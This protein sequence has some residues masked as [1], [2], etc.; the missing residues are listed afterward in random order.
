[1]FVTW[2]I[3][4]YSRLSSSDYEWESTPTVL[5][6]YYDVLLSASIG[7]GKDTFSFKMLNNNGALDSYFNIGDKVSIYRAVNTTTIDSSNLLMSGIITDLPY[8]VDGSKNILTVKGA[9]YTEM[10]MN[11]I[12][13]VSAENLTI[14]EYLQQALNS[15]NAFNDNFKITWSSSNPSLNSNDQPFP[16]IDEKWNYK[17][18]LL[19]LEKYS[20]S[21]YTL[22]GNYYFFI[23]NINE[24]V[25]AKRSDSSTDSF[26]SSTD[27]HKMLSIKKDLKG[28]VNFVIIKGKNSPGGKIISTRVDDPISRSKNGFK[29]KIIISQANKVSDLLQIDGINQNSYNGYP[30]DFSSPFTTVWTCHVNRPSNPT[31]DSGSTVTCNSDNEYDTAIVEEMKGYWL[32]QEGIAYINEYKNGKKMIDIEFI[33]GKSWGLGDVINCTIPQADKNNNPMRVSEVQYSTTGDVYTLIEDE[34]TL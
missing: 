26:D 18:L 5:N 21:K 30:S 20:T 8:T 28:V 32:K 7:D 19:L 29:P 3:E 12:T 22:D 31:M 34:G 10:L 13:F 9:N 33:P 14:P 15:V 25:W 11:A 4:L 17:S 27:N 23:N 6:S 24:L 16:V 1:M 2:K